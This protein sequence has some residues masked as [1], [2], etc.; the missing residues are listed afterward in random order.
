[1]GVTNMEKATQ[2]I[3]T[4]LTSTPTI[5]VSA[6]F[7]ALH[8]ASIA[9]DLYCSTAPTHYSGE[10]TIVEGGDFSMYGIED[11][12]DMAQHYYDCAYSI[13][14]SV[15]NNLQYSV[16]D[17]Y[18][19]IEDICADT[20]VREE[21]SSTLYNA[22]NSYT[23]TSK[24]DSNIAWDYAHLTEEQGLAL[25]QQIAQLEKQLATLKSQVTA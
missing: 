1:M 16:Q 11:S 7:T 10:F 19:S 14:N 20:V 13:G 24:E 9:W 4:M 12:M 22:V 5:T 25:P 21:V 8:L 2:T 3:N 6:K 15:V 23:H 18:D 17:A